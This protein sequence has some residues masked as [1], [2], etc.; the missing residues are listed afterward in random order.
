MTL[1]H[2]PSIVKDGMVIYLDAANIKSY[3]GS[4]TTWYD[5]S[6]KGYNATLSNNP[7]LSNGMFQMRSAN[8]SCAS[9]LF[10]EGVLK[11]TNE[12]GSW[13]IEVLFKYVS[14]PSSDEAFVAGRI[15]CHGGIYITASG[16]LRYEIKTNQCWTGHSSVSA[17]TLVANNFYH[18]VMTYS[19]GTTYGYLNGQYINSS[20]IDLATYDLNT[21]SNDFCIGGWTNT[22]MYR[23]NTD[24][25]I[26][27]CY[28]KSLSSS[29][30]KQNFNSLRGRYGI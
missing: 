17:G 2:S 29:E 8:G 1:S 3:P 13:S 6:G 19:N 20:S 22:T 10:N 27:R 28:D 7:V 23:T 18:A 9:A 30:I 16:T 12:S 15:G 26:V 14:A 21:Y 4:G 11:S 25:S 5:L 24:I